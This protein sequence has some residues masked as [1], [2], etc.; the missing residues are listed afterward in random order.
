MKRRNK[1]N[2]KKTIVDGIAFDS[3]REALRYRALKVREAKGEIESLELQPRYRFT[4]GGVA[5]K[6]ENG[7]QLAYTADFTYIETATRRR[8]IE[9]VKG[10]KT[11]AFQ[12]RRAIMRAMGHEIRI[13]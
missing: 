9:D 3:R 12:L 1:F 10:V 5:I 4:V 2:A 8:V 13:I 11:E 7:R 6:A